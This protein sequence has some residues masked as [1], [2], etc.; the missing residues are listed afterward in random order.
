MPLLDMY[1]KPVPPEEEKNGTLLTP[2]SFLIHNTKDAMIFNVVVAI[3]PVDEDG[4][5]LA[6][7]LAPLFQPPETASAMI[8]KPFFINRH[9]FQTAKE[10][11]LVLFSDEWLNNKDLLEPE[12]T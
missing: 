7:F 3:S 9:N 5:Q 8:Q 10:R 4:R 11:G 6:M 1:G 2:S 12:T